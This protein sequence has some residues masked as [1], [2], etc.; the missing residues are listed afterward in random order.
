MIDASG[1][2]TEFKHESLQALTFSGLERRLGENSTRQDLIEMVNEE[3]IIRYVNLV[4]LQA[5]EEKASDVHFEPFEEEFRIRYRIDGVLYDLAS[6]P[7]HLALP[8]ISRIKI[9]ADMNIAERRVPQDGHFKMTVTGRSVDLRVSTIPVQYGESLVLRV[10]DK[11]VVNLN[12]DELGI[13]DDLL[14]RVRKIT[15]RPNGIFIIT[16]PTGSGKT[17]TLYSALREIN[18]EAY[19][20]LTA[21]DPVEYEI[22]G[23]IQVAI[24]PNVGLTFSRVLRSFL[25]QDPDKIMVGEIRD[26]ESAR[27]A[28]QAAFTG[29][30]VFSTLHTIDTVGAIYP[31]YRFRS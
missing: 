22:D 1:G 5:I 16:G 17:T 11:F 8:L 31:V 19:K 27:I 23:L 15:A 9:L 21:E 12:L 28:V 4:I 14:K 26:L 10:L 25:R 24:N 20:I 3:P 7:T 6:P 29:H 30:L 18:H 13:P 2:L